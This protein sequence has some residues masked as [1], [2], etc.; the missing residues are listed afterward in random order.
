MPGMLGFILL[1][2]VLPD[3]G[4]PLLWGREDLPRCWD[5]SCWVGGLDTRVPFLAGVEGPYSD[6]RVPLI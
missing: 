4:I 5:S 2:K 1:G 6:A 3:T